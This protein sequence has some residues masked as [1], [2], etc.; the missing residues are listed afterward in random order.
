MD[1]Y[2]ILGLDVGIARVGLAIANSTAKIPSPLSVVNN[3]E[4]VFE[5]IKGLADDEKVK[6][7]VIGLPRNMQGQETA[8]SEFARSFA[9]KLG[10]YV[11]VTVEFADE[12]LSSK[13]AEQKNRYSRQAT[14]KHLDDVAAC[15]ILEEY[16]GRN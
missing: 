9:R 5:R 4:R 10:G 1:T 8:Q 7:I 15:F 12:S 16:F 3:D 14:G 6:I 11:D 13:R 2:N